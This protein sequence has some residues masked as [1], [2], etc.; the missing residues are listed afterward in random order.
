MFRIFHKKGYLKEYITMQESPTF[1]VVKTKNGQ[2]THLL[3]NRI[4]RSE[5]NNVVS[6]N[7]RPSTT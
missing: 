6:C 2:N 7:H 5:L 4:Q 3:K 1:E